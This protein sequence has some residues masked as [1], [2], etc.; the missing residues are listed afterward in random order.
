MT[1]F[2]PLFTSINSIAIHSLDVL[3]KLQCEYSELAIAIHIFTSAKYLI[4]ALVLT[5]K[6]IFAKI[7]IFS[8]NCRDFW[9]CE[10]LHIPRED[11]KPRALYLSGYQED[12]LPLS[13]Y[14]FIKH[15]I[16]ACKIF[17]EL[18]CK[19]NE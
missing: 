6:F 1:I 14:H 13:L 17:I 19:T 2:L 15:I 11:G 5:K 12:R 4:T 3:D 9:F 16:K 10:W 8:Y 7:F 18:T